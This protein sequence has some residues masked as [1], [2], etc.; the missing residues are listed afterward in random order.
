MA[1]TTTIRVSTATRDRLSA[2]AAHKRCS[3]GEIVAKLVAAAYDEELLLADAEVAFERLPSD[4][5]TF[6]SYSSQAREI[7]AGFGSLAL[8]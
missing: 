5:Q 2:L 6:A 1:G 4:P 7:E 8:E 3:A